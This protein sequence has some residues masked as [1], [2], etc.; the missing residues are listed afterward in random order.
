MKK[1]SKSGNERKMIKNDEVEANETEAGTEKTNEVERK[2][3][4]NL[5][6]ERQ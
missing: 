4:K 2:R 6:Q 3:K 5:K 1:R